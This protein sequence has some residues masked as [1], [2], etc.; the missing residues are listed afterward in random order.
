MHSPKICYDCIACIILFLSQIQFRCPKG[1]QSS[2]PSNLKFE[3]EFRFLSSNFYVPWLSFWI[4]FW[5]S[6]SKYSKLQFKSIGIKSLNHCPPSIFLKSWK[7][8]FKNQIDFWIQ[9]FQ[10]L[11]IW[12]SFSHSFL[13]FIPWESG[14]PLLFFLK[15]ASGIQP[16]SASWPSWGHPNVFLVGTECQ[17]PPQRRSALRHHAGAPRPAL[18]YPKHHRSPP[19]PFPP[20]NYVTPISSP[21]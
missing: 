3:S 21:L 18:S 19:L 6:I 10:L 9:P 17:R 7:H 15:F 5:N 16:N 11:K 20:I 14:R 2:F 13:T 1:C 4:E 12:N 8:P